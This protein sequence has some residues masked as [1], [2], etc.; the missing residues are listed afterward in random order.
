MR[1][2]HQCHLNILDGFRSRYQITL[3]HCSLLEQTLSCPLWITRKMQLDELMQYNSDVTLQFDDGTLP[4]NTTLLGM[5]SSVLRGAMEAEATGA[6]ADSKKRARDSI[7]PISGTTKDEWTE[8]AQFL[9]P[10][11]PPPT[12]SSWTQLEVLLKVSRALDMPLL[13]HM[14][15]VYMASHADELVSDAE[16]QPNVW[17]WLRLADKAG[18]VECIPVLAKRTAK[19]DR[20]ACMQLSSLQDL[21]PTVLQHLIVAC[22]SLQ[23]ACTLGSTSRLQCFSCSGFGSARQHTLKWV[24]DNCNRGRA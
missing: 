19:V 10:V 24:C 16:V 3:Y 23:P 14:A 17:K 8:V 11:V 12:I 22:A 4:G 18:L 5:H 20:D 9:Y 7:I 2:M 6:P 13:L 21:S 15:D 1:L